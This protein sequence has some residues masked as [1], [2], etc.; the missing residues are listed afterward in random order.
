MA[1]PAESDLT[2]DAFLG[3][4]LRLLQPARGFRAGIDS[5][6]LAAAIPA[7][8]G[9]SA[10]E[11]GAGAGVASLCLARRL[12]GLTVTGLEL[13][14]DLA[15]LANRNAGRNGLAGR[16]LFEAGSL[17]APS[18]SI[19]RYPH[20]LANPPFLEE[21]EAV[22]SGERGRRQARQGPDGT[23]KLFIDFCIRH[24]E[25]G[26]SVTLIHRA[27]RL[28]RILG[29]LEGRLGALNI[30]PLWPRAGLPA[31][32]I[33]IGG[34]VGSAAPLTLRCGL[35]LHGEGH[36]FTEAAEAVLRHGA[37]LPLYG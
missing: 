12:D 1:E 16:V 35:V 27:D 36:G 23:L 2:D 6:L 18:P 11:A 10:L 4:A 14:P 29:V 30:W 33:L 3:G 32:R 8:G 15:A 37:P 21:G 19:G 20:V 28:D 13:D 24:A 7:A 26:G 31:K 34:R 22:A 9:Q 5:V 25:P 17:A